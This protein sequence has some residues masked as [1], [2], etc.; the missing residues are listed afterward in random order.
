MKPAPSI[1]KLVASI[2]L[3]ESRAAV[4]PDSIA[5]VFGEEHLS[6]AELNR[7]ANQ[8]ARHLQASGVKAGDFVGICLPHRLE[9]LVGLLGVLKVGAGYVPIDPEYPTQRI[10]FML[11]DSGVTTVL[12]DRFFVDTVLECGVLPICL[13][14]DWTIF[15]Q[16]N[17]DN[18]QASAVPQKISLT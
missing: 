16:E 3:I 4:Q 15:D 10:A 1:P 13:E 17:T 9:E 8:L 2:E 12:T 7:R 5:A 14:A 11:A 18:I 6:Y